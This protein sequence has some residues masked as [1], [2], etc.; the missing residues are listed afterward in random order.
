MAALSVALPHFLAYQNISRERAE[1]IAVLAVEVF[2]VLSGYVLAPQI[3]FCL[4]SGRPRSLAVFLGRRWMRTVPPYVV[5]LLLISLL[6]EQAGSGDFFRYLFYVQNLFRQENSNDYFAIAWSLSVEE[7]FYVSFPSALLA[8]S[9]ISGRRDWR[10]AFLFGLCFCVLIATVRVL[11]GDAGDWGAAVRRVVIFRLDS[12]GYGFLLYLVV[13]R[14]GPA[15]LSFVPLWAIILALSVSVIA[16]AALLVRIA[17]ASAPVAEQLFPFAAAVFGGAAVVLAVRGE[18]AI[19]V[20]PGLAWCSAWLGRISYS[21]YLF[22]I[23]LIELVGTLLASFGVAT[24][25]VL[26]IVA[27]FAV[28]SVFYVWFERPILARRPRYGGGRRFV[29]KSKQRSVSARTSPVAIAVNAFLVLGATAVGLLA[30]ELGFRL[31]DGYRV[32]SVPLIIQQRADVKRPGARLDLARSLLI[33][34]DFDPDW[35]TADPP[36]PSVP[37][38]DPLPAVWSAGLEQVPA[39]PVRGLPAGF[40]RR[41]YQFLYNYDYLVRSCET[42]KL[43]RPLQAYRESPGFVFAFRN[44]DD[45]ASPD[46]R[47]RPHSADDDIHYDNYG[48]RGPDIQM[49]KPRRTIRVAFLGASTTQMG[50]PWTYPEYAVQYLR[51]WARAQGLDVDF[52]V[53]NA[54]RAGEDSG[55]IAGIFR[56]EVA[57]LQPDIVVYYEGANDFQPRDIVEKPADD[58]PAAALKPLPL[59]QYSAMANRTYELLFRRGGPG[60]EPPK[61]PHNLKFDVFNKNPVISRPDLPFRL[62]QQAADFQNMQSLAEQIGASYFIASFV[63]LVQDRLLLDQESDANIS[64]IL[65]GEYYP[66]TYKEIRGAADYENRAFAEIAAADRLPFIDVARYFPQE[67]SLFGDMEHFRDEGYRIQGWIFAQL[68]APYIKR[69]IEAG[70]L[71]RPYDANVPAADWTRQKPIRFDLRTCRSD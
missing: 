13:S 43:N 21:T 3:I 19:Q 20:Y 69:D 32:D 46:Y 66:L 64:R 8:A 26:F 24:Q 11:F 57:P 2:F 59:G 41:E 55:A 1:T 44:G 50:S 17:E 30:D 58:P 70:T 60:A 25:A 10:F 48:F 12:I 56:Y 37:P 15:R 35:Y 71:P 34:R 28:T 52:D 5:A 53:I 18:H 67:P 9:L 45:S 16:T 22:H 54:A 7:W 39:G 49:P 36:K 65:N 4:A 62:H 51:L 61:P 63:M 14:V 38:Q 23:I 29:A 6:A 33:D 68:L 47:W 40:L 42:G 27:L 31:I